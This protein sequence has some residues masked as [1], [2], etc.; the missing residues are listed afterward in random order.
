M[1]GR[2]LYTNPSSKVVS[3]SL[4]PGVLTCVQPDSDPFA[5]LSV[6]DIVDEAEVLFVDKANAVFF[7]LQS[8]TALAPVRRL[9]KKE[10]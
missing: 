4:L 10:E 5:G 1:E 3:I 8:C 9:L 6:G 2:I 7:R